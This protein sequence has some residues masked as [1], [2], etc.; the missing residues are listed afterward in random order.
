[1]TNG[2]KQIPKPRGKKTPN[3]S[4]LLGHRGPPG[5]PLPAA[6]KERRARPLSSPGG[7]SCPLPRDPF[8][9][10]GSPSPPQG[11]PPRPSLGSPFPP[12]TPLPLPGRP[13]GPGRLSPTGRGQACWEA[14]TR[15]RAQART[16]SPRAERWG[17]CRGRP[18]G[19]AGAADLCLPLALPAPTQPPKWTPAPPPA[20]FT[21]APS[22]SL[23]RAASEF[24]FRTPRPQAAAPR[25]LGLVVFL[26][27]R[28]RRQAPQ[29]P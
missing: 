12:Q 25:P 28:P 27:P 8:P 11:P 18:S 16:A 22:P 7:P 6:G 13:A 14:A 3:R 15:T 10:P 4:P 9:C 19:R 23:T 1:M 29:R 17:T 26:P 24:L 21:P 5:P 2:Q 20:A